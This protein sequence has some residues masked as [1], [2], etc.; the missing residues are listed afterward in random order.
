LIFTTSSNMRR[1]ET[2]SAVKSIKRKN[3][4]RTDVHIKVQC[5]DC[6]KYRWIRK[7]HS[8][9]VAFTGRCVSCSRH[10]GQEKRK[11]NI[12]SICKICGKKVYH[13]KSKHPKYCSQGC[14]WE[15]KKDTWPS[16][17][18]KG[19]KHPNWKGGITPINKR[20]RLRFRTSLQKKIFERDG[21]KCQMCG[22]G[23]NLQIDHIQ[24][25]ADFV[26]ERFN[27]DNCR[28]L[29]VGCHY[30]ITFGKE[31]PENVAAWGHNLKFLEGRL[32]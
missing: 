15:D 23:G 16:I 1:T 30:L 12:L 2:A 4:D 13:R 6:L 5:P 29:C 18:L 22:S 10:V 7:S 8:K 14:C 3:S 25:W 28:T 20:E 24:P 21:Y 26:E 19:A 32:D 9:S 11:H 31:M 17:H 27:M